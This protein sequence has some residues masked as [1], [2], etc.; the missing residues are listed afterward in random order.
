MTAEPST[1]GQLTRRLLAESR[2]PDDDPAAAV[3]DAWDACDRV[4]AEFSRWV[5]ARGFYALASRALTEARAGHP[6]LADIR[7]E[8]RAEHG[9][10][11]VAESIQRRG[12]EATAQ[13]LAALLECVLALCVRLI[14]ADIVTTLVEKTMENRTPGDLGRS[15]S[16]AHRRTEP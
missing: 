11:G 13:A 14:G 16:P 3:A 6:A 5:G 7:Y 4:S 10:S 15:R 8:L 12:A 9:W 1:A 2:G